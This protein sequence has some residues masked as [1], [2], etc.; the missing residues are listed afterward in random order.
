MVE[1]S[2]FYILS[3]WIKPNDNDDP[4]SWWF[5]IRSYMYCNIVLLGIIYAISSL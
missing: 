2:T 1:L 5:M 3:Q 4:F